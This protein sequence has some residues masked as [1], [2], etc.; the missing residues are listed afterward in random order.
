MKK[1]LPVRT[2]SRE[3][4]EML[5]KDSNRVAQRI[6]RIGHEDL[7]DHMHHRINDQLDHW[8]QIR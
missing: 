4:A 6:A 7:Y 2:P 8:E 3:L 1:P 5:L